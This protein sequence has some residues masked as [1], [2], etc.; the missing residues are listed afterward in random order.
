MQFV[1]FLRRLTTVRSSD[2]VDGSVTRKRLADLSAATTDILRKHGIPAAW[3]AAE[4][5][6]ARTPS[7]QRGVHLRLVVRTTNPKLLH[8]VFALQ[9]AIQARLAQRDAHCAQWLVGTSW[10]LELPAASKAGELP[11]PEFWQGSSGA[12]A[13]AASTAP[14]AP[15]ATAPRRAQP[16]AREI[17][18]RKLAARDRAFA[19]T[20]WE[21]PDFLPTQPI[22]VL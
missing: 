19:S 10:R 14:A 5:L 1:S 7:D 16:S 12:A 8:H 17:V 21:S 3:I 2:V 22:G 18:S 9:Q 13:S 11:G 15:V 20:T 6:S 4:T